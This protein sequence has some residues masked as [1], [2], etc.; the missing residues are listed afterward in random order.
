M[1]DR[2]SARPD[3]GARGIFQTNPPAVEAF[4]SRIFPPPYGGILRIIDR[5]GRKERWVR[6]QAEGEDPLTLAV[7][8]ECLSEDTPDVA[9][10]ACSALL[11]PLG[12]VVLRQRGAPSARGAMAANAMVLDGV[13]ALEKVF[14]EA[15]EDGR[16]D[17]RE[18]MSIAAATTEAKV[19][20]DVLLAQLPE[21]MKP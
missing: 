17:P 18:A 11:A 1:L 6:G 5:L 21:L 8:L 12:L 19:R 16:I 10:S 20:L 3:V 14:A 7:S 2:K 15:V 9:E 4:R 13:A